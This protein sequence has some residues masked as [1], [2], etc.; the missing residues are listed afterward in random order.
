MNCIE[1]YPSELREE[2][3]QIV[4]GGKEASLISKLGSLEKDLHMKL[5][6]VG[7]EEKSPKTN[8]KKPRMGALTVKRPNRK[9]AIKKRDSKGKRALREVPK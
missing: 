3:W 5:M 2:G 9:M 8:G 1:I 4:P 7:L 6:N